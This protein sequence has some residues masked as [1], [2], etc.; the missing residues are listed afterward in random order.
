[1]GQRRG[2]AGVWGRAFRQIEQQVQSPR[3]GVSLACENCEEVRLDT[4]EQA[5]GWEE[6]FGKMGLCH[7][8][9]LWLSCRMRWEPLEGSERALRLSNVYA[10]RPQR[11]T[12]GAREPC[13]EAISA[14]RDRDGGTWAGNGCGDGERGEGWIL[15]DL[16]L[17][18]SWTC[19]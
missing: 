16:T 5:R 1:M 12:G 2:P 18:M 8:K 3:G 6:Q 19:V 9:G 13:V 11:D 4:A 14:V 10:N 17:L 7:C 15:V